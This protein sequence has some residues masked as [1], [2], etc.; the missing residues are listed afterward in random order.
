MSGN[1]S[2]TSKP[3]PVV[4]PIIYLALIELEETLEIMRGFLFPHFKV[5]I[6]TQQ[7]SLSI[8]FPCDSP[9]P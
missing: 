4:A 5:L 7:C 3:G 2:F 6:N 9:I 8:Y 1:P